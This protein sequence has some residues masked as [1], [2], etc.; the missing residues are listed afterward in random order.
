MINGLYH[1]K[2]QREDYPFGEFGESA[3]LNLLSQ[4][5]VFDFWN[6]LLIIGIIK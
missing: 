5:N 6:T 2:L 3:I 4:I 1:F